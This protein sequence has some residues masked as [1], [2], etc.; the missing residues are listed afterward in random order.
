[1]RK[2]Y[3]LFNLS[4]WVLNLALSQ[5]NDSVITIINGSFEGT[6]RCCKPPDSWIDCGSKFETPPDVHPVISPNEPL[7]AVT[8]IAQD[9]NTYLG[10]VVRQNET[11]ES[12]NQKLNKPLL[13]G[14]CYSFSVYMARSLEY[15]SA[16]TTD[17]HKLKP[18]ATPALLQIW[19]GDTCC[20]RKELLATSPLV[21]NTEWQRFDFEFRSQS[22]ITFFRLEAYFKPLSPFPYN[23]NILLDNASDIILIPCKTDK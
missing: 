18:F 10:M 12:I 3:I 23:G 14:K 5:Q 4:L 16:T 20:H 22:K 2:F 13:A 7:F 6:P 11:Y 9:G 21:E 8:K 19:G 1:M 17:A 15:I